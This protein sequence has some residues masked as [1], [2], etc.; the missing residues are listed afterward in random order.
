MVK[1]RDQADVDAVELFEREEVVEV[2]LA[3]D[4]GFELPLQDLG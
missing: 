2:F 1:R 4:D 3:F